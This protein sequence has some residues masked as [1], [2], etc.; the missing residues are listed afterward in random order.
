MPKE[1]PTYLSVRKVA[2]RYDVDV[3]TPWR[4]VAQGKFPA[5][6]KIGGLT[7]WLLSEIE[8]HEAKAAAQREA[9]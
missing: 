5:P 8:D 9:A 6:V 4:W 1:A 3:S 2:E 7:R